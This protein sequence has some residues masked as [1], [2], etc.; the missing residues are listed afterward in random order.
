MWYLTT[1]C[2]APD[3]LTSS[4][5]LF[6]SLDSNGINGWSNLFSLCCTSMP[7]AP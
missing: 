7:G 4:G 6:K 1:E 3:T 2:S 5:T